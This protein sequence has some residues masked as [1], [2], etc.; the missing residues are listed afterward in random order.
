MK[1]KE[2]KGGWISYFS[3]FR[4]LAKAIRVFDFKQFDI[5]KL[6]SVCYKN[7][8]KCGEQNCNQLEYS[9]TDPR[10]T[11]LLE[12]QE[13]TSLQSIGIQPDG[14]NRHHTV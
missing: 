14:S 8:S 9:L 11:A 4:V 12:F 6:V 13:S 3:F 10:G 7:L 5:I 2:M 1:R